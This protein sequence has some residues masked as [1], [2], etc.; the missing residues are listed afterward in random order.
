MDRDQQA[1]SVD[2]VADATERESDLNTELVYEGATKEG[3]D[4]EGAVE[5]GV[6][7]HT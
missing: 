1:D 2:A 5:S 4:S 6:L 7:C 3:E